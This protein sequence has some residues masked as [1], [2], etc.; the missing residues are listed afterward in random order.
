VGEDEEGMDS[1]QYSSLKCG[2]CEAGNFDGAVNG[3]GGVYFSKE[4]NFEEESIRRVLSC[5]L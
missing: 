1:F 3:G 2:L 4:N 5:G